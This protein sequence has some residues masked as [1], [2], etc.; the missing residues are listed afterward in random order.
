[1]I[2]HYLIAWTKALLLTGELARCEAK[3]LRYRLLHVAARLAF[4]G[5]Q[6]KL[7]LKAGSRAEAALDEVGVQRGRDGGVLGRPLP[8][9]E[10][11]FHSVGS[12]PERHDVRAPL[13]LD[14][15]AHHRQTHAS[16][17]R[18]HERVQVVAPPG[19]ELAA[20]RFDLAGDRLARA[21]QPARGDPGPF[22]LA[23][24]R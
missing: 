24:P 5:R 6:A 16:R 9:S 1:L 22:R 23:R 14:P 2:A 17:R 8:K 20:D 15:V 4:H 21:L 13:E 19:D 7:R 11:D 3:R 10:W 12:D 18:R